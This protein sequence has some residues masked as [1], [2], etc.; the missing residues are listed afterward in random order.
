MRR[1]RTGRA[2]RAALGRLGTA[3]RTS[4]SVFLW[5]VALVAAMAGQARAEAA[6]VDQT[7]STTMSTA[8][9]PD[10]LP[11]DVSVATAGPLTALTIT[12]GALT[13]V[14]SGAAVD[15][16]GT[17]GVL[18]PQVGATVIRGSTATSP[19]VTWAVVSRDRVGADLV[20]LTTICAP[21]P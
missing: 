5:A 18:V 11:V 10:R 20:G 1:M 4:I 13:C 16:A 21:A 2:G 17:I 7:G 15:G 12:S 8:S 9:R 19:S 6:A 3:S 14:Q